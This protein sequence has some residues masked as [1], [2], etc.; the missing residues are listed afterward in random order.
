MKHQLFMQSLKAL[1]RL[2]VFVQIGNPAGRAPEIE[3][4]PREEE[5]IYGPLAESHQ[6]FTWRL[7]NALCCGLYSGG[8]INQRNN[9]YLRLTA[10]PWGKELHPS[11][12]SP[13]LGVMRASVNKAVF[14]LTPRAKGNYYH[15]L[16][17]LLPRLLLVQQ[18]GLADF[19]ER[20]IVL[21]QPSRR[22]E[23]DT[24]RLLG[25]PE[26][27][28]MRLHPF[29]TLSVN[30]LVVTD[31]LHSRDGQYFPSW[32]KWLLDGFKEKMLGAVPQN[33]TRKIYL[34]R[35]KQRIRQLLGEERLVKILKGLGFEILDPQQLTLLEQMQAL[36]EAAV[37]VGLHGAAL[38]NIIFCQPGTL[39]VE[40]RS[41]Y[42]PPEHYAEIAKTYQLQ[43]E[44]VSLEPEKI[45]EKPNL[46]LKQHLLLSDQ[47]IEKLL[48]KLQ[49][50]ENWLQH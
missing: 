27:Q 36:S 3:L 40:L 50:L 29:D 17:D 43:F 14:L 46:A 4:E 1:R 21:H 32:K 45:V 24:L 22:Y 30:D 35:G 23:N 10:F 44:T 15:W 25:I 26:E 47:K 2:A 42:K 38:T 11:L 20:I 39:V 49:L 48:S 13:Y 16:A 7:K 28:V 12:C 9:V 37:V 6:I 19:S 31:Y 8:V 33:P 5:K 41:S 18:S 34:L